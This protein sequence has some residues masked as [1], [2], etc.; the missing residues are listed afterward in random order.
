MSDRGEYGEQRGRGMT[1][2]TIAALGLV[3]LGVLVAPVVAIVGGTALASVLGGRG[4][5]R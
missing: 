4:G 2:S 5:K 1:P 3:V